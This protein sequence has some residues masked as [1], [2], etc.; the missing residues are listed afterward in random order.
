MLFPKIS[1]F[2]Y[3]MSFQ[4]K[5]LDWFKENRRPFPWRNKPEP[6][7]VWL[8][9][10]ILQQTRAAQVTYYESFISNFPSIENWLGQKTK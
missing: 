2:N 1:L 10:I 6:Y 8:S 9:E 3:K 4:I 5:L 7:N